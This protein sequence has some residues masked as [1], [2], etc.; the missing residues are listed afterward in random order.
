MAA[1]SRLLWPIACLAAVA[2]CAGCGRG[3]TEPLI[4]G[5]EAGQAPETKSPPIASEVPLVTASTAGGAPT[6]AAEAALGVVDR[7]IFSDLDAKVQL[8]VRRDLT[9]AALTALVDRRRDL[10]VLY[11]RDWPVK[12]YP[13]GGSSELAVGEHRLGLRPGDRAEL[14]PLLDPARVRELA[15]GDV[16]PPGDDDG[17]GIPDPLDVLLGGYKNSLNA[18]VYS[19]GYMLIDFPGGDVPRDMGVCT[20]VIVRALRNAGLDLQAEVQR[21]IRRAPRAFPMVKR[22]NGHIDHRRVK[23]VLPYFERRWDRRRGALDD[24][25]DPLRPGDVIF[26]DTFPGK[27]G[28]DHVG[29]LSDRRGPSGMP[30]VINSWTDGFR[31]SEMDLLP[32]IPVTHRFRYPSR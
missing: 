20:D 27:P 14:A 6:A 28:P 31:T 25:E 29:I 9:P 17:D 21:E 13:L 18:A 5:A 11:E 3:L 24:P 1:G 10:V 8:E 12:V 15:A 7:G 30:L 32:S 2:T 26:M 16:A 23:T 4:E 19:G 22:P